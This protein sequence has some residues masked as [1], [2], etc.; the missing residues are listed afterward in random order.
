MR[1][2]SSGNLGKRAAREFLWKAVHNCAN[3]KEAA[4]P[5]GKPQVQNVDFLSA[6]VFY[7]HGGIQA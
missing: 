4:S 3:S 6:E 5:S 1:I 2:R 7:G